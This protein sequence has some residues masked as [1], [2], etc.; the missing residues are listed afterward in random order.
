M[1]I[2]GLNIKT[3]KIEPNE[4][5][6][7]FLWN[8][9]WFWSAML[10]SNQQNWHFD[11]KKDDYWHLV[12]V[13][14]ICY[15]NLDSI[16]FNSVWVCGGNIIWEI[17][18]MITLLSL[19]AIHFKWFSIGSVSQSAH[20]LQTHSTHSIKT[21]LNSQRNVLVFWLAHSSQYPN[22]SVKTFENKYIHFDCF[23]FNWL[24][25]D[26]SNNLILLTI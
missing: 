5:H 11:E 6:I 2:Q 9:K 26:S 24:I 1:S 16:Q 10:M 13:M 23:S 4:K 15:F 17:N 12:N 3:S 21:N 22:K 7:K 25:C 19:R 20:A 14:L 18:K 8:N